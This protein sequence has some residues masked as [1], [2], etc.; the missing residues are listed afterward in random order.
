MVS[1]RL[2]GT[3]YI[4]TY[5]YD[6]KTDH[7][8]S[9]SVIDTRKEIQMSTTTHLKRELKKKLKKLPCGLRGLLA[10]ILVVIWDSNTGEFYVK[11]N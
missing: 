7:F 8:I 4:H 11:F 10:D 6:I 3:I 9:Y 5:V 2:K 1:F